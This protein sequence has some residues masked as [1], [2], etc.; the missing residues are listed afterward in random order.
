MALLTFF[1]GSYS[2]MLT[3]EI[4]G[5]GEGIYTVQ[6]DET[7]GELN[8]LHAINVVNPSYLTISSDHKFLYCSTEL[9]EKFN[10]KVQAYKINDDFSLSFLNEQP[11]P[12]GYPCHIEKS[13]NNILVACYQTGNIIQYPIDPFGK[14]KKYIKNFQHSGT[15]IN[16]ER[17]EGPHAHQVIVHPNKKQL[18]VCDLGMDT[19]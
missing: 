6:L 19:N 17:Q 12:G 3:P 11:I 5:E 10:P 1:I 13:D 9:D 4:I 7:T 2:Q 15:S 18:Y 14:L 8:I 16:S